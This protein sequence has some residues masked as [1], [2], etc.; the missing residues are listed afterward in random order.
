MISWPDFL[1]W[2]STPT[3]IP[4]ASG[5]LVYIIKDLFFPQFEQLAPKWQ[6]VV[7]FFV[8]LIPPVGAAGLGILTLGWSPAWE[9]TWWPAI[10]AG[11]LAFAGSIVIDGFAPIKAIRRLLKRAA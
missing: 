11:V 8:N 3:G 2:L 4:I 5:V 6:Q 1:R 10:V 7:F 9:V